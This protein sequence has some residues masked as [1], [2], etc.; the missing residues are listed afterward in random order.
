MNVR[1]TT[2]S[3]KRFSVFELFVAVVVGAFILSIFFIFVES[4][5]TRSRDTRREQDIKQLQTALNLYQAN[6]RRFPICDPVNLIDRCLI[7][8]VTEGAMPTLPTDPLHESVGIC[9]AEGS[10]V[11]C[12]KSA[13]G[14]SYDLYYN[15][16]TDTISG[17]SA[18][19]QRVSS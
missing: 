1:S 18:G 16:E 5:R 17:K 15:L 2:F 13:R 11:Y 9:E 12:Y 4:V 8:L 19:W 3:R 7:P 14:S 10:H 6:H